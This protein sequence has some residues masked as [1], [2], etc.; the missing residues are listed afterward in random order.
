MGEWV[1]IS[2]S[3][4]AKEIRSQRDDDQ[5]KRCLEEINVRAIGRPV[6]LFLLLFHPL[7]VLFFLSRPSGRKCITLVYRCQDLDHTPESSRR[8][9]PIFFIFIFFVSA[10]QRVI[11]IYIS[12]RI[13]SFFVC[14]C[15]EEEEEGCVD[16]LDKEEQS[17]K[18]SL[19][20]TKK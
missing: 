8:F 7:G 17:R 13:I 4:V 15:E 6:F 2:F 19:L 16:G 3:F 18:I 11:Y 20:S 10:C 14:V 9:P 1:V 5:R 12:S